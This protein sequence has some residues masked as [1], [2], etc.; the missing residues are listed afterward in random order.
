MLSGVHLVANIG[1]G[2]AVLCLSLLRPKQDNTPPAAPE[3]HSQ[4]NASGLTS[5]HSGKKEQRQLSRTSSW[6][7]KSCWGVTAHQ[8]RPPETL[9]EYFERALINGGLRALLV[10]PND[11]GYEGDAPDTCIGTY[12]Y[13]SSV[14]FPALHLLEKHVIRTLRLDDDLSKPDVH[15]FCLGRATEQLAG[16][17]LKPCVEVQ[18]DP[19]Q[20]YAGDQ[21]DDLVAYMQL[22]V[23]SGLPSVAAVRLTTPFGHELIV[24]CSCDGRLFVVQSNVHGPTSV[25]DWLLEGRPAWNPTLAGWS[26]RVREFLLEA[27]RDETTARACNN[28]DRCYSDLTLRR[29][30][31]L[32][33][34][35]SVASWDWKWGKTPQPS[36][37][38]ANGTHIRF[39]VQSYDKATFED[40]MEKLD[41]YDDCDVKLRLHATKVKQLED[42]GIEG[43]QASRML[44]D[45]RADGDLRLALRLAMSESSKLQ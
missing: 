44:Q 45:P 17:Q 42:Y 23:A 2:F 32:F 18:L 20:A 29:Y 41:K 36:K 30:G 13:I 5:L 15:L 6:S 1:T 43:G 21:L 8:V 7:D 31:T 35:N 14:F 12:Q 16:E 22:C 39:V 26:D 40:A 19:A 4:P 9:Q 24:E 25:Q 3:H 11:C 10:L 37:A 28:T 27:N 34:A 38:H 33:T